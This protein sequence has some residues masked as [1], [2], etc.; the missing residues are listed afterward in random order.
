MKSE[1]GIFAIRKKFSCIKK[2]EEEKVYVG[3]YILLWKFSLVLDICGNAYT[4]CSVQLQKL[5]KLL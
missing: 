3:V 1:N 2:D 4:I 5:Y